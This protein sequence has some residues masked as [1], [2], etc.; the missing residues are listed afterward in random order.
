MQETI[1]LI[2]HRELRNLRRFTRETGQPTQLTSLD[3]GEMTHVQSIEIDE[4]HITV[5]YNTKTVRKY[6][7]NEVTHKEWVYKYNEDADFVAAVRTVIEQSRKHLYDLPDNLSCPPGCAECCSGY[8][9]FVSR[10]DVQR[11]ADRFGMTY[12]EAMK[13]Y[14]VARDSADGYVVG[15]LRKVDDDGGYSQDAKH[16]C[17]FLMGSRSGR[18]YCGIYDSRPSD[19]AE[20]T[21]IGCDDV[22]E[23]L[24]HGGAYKVGRPF[25]PRHR[26][27]NGVPGSN[28]RRMPR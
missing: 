8:E 13:E 18:Y 20:F 15:W 16:K 28:G 1:D 27:K 9:P 5:K 25:E 23:D 22:D 10:A 21:P 14:V 17:V 24:A 12:D 3:L 11:I 7:A 2:A 26:S 6:N 4:E 19:C